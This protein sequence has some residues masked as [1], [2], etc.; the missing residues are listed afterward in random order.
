MLPAGSFLGG[1]VDEEVVCSRLLD[2]IQSP[3]ETGLRMGF[4][5]AAAAPPLLRPFELVRGGMA[6][7]D[8]KVSETMMVRVTRTPSNGLAGQEGR[9]EDEGSWADKFGRWTA[10]VWL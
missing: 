1:S 10:D 5:A 4:A 6:F 2:A 3:S 9:R 8:W 7:G